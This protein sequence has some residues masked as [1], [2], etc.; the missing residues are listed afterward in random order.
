MLQKLQGDNIETSSETW[1]HASKEESSEVWKNC[2]PNS[3]N[4]C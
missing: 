4:I 2:F 1:G 3:V